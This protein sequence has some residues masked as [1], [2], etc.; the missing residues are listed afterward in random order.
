LATTLVTPLIDQV[1]GLACIKLVGNDNITLI[2]Q[3]Q[4]E[5]QAGAH[6]SPPGCLPKLCSCS[7]VL[8]TLGTTRA[9]NASPVHDLGRA[10]KPS[11]HALHMLQA[12]A[13]GDEVTWPSS[14][15]APAAGP[16]EHTAERT[17]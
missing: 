16:A 17:H 11:L 9:A 2:L 13:D 7:D 6:L 1:V 14:G 12:C 8:W 5:K 4:A 15:I 10:I 3:P